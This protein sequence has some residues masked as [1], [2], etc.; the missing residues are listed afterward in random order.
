[1]AA[2]A[3][4][5]RVPD[6]GRR[7]RALPAYQHQGETEVTDVVVRR[8]EADDSRVSARMPVSRRGHRSLPKFAL[9]SPFLIA[10]RYWHEDFSRDAYPT[11]EHFV[12]HLAEILAAEARGLVEVGIDIVQIDDPA[13]TYFCDRQLTGRR[14]ETTTTGCG[15]TGTST[16]NFP[17]AL[18]GH[19]PRCRGAAGGGASALLPQRLQTA[20]RRRGRLQTDSAAAREAK[21]RSRQSGVRVSQDTGDVSD[22]ALLPLH[23]GV[24]MGVVD[25]RGERLQTVEE[26]EALAQQGARFRPGPDGAQPRLRLRPRRRRTAD[27]RRSLRKAQTVSGGSGDVTQDFNVKPQAATRYSE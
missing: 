22:L 11:L 16:G 3:V 7:L 2:D 24:G 13:L 14:L 10:V 15:A 19:Q 6:A 26:I 5:R 23:L 20:E 12:D 18:G 21:S 9:P 4:H 8:M 25:V 17:E 27:H 1:M